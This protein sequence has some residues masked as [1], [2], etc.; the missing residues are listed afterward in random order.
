MLT[1]GR[2][3]GIGLA[4]NDREAAERILLDFSRLVKI[5]ESEGR[6][7]LVRVIR[8]EI[9]EEVAKEVDKLKDAF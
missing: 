6:E 3:I 9:L 1:F 5:L 2:L 7:K 4:L 8:E